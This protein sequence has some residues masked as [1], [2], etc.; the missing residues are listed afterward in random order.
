MNFGT[1]ESSVGNREVDA[2]SFEMDHALPE[3]ALC[4]CTRNRAAS[5]TRCLEH[6]ASLETDRPWELVVVDN[7]S[8][9]DTPAVLEAFGARLPQLRV[10]HEPT[11]GLGRARNS[12]WRASSAPIVAFTDDD[13]YV[14]PD[15]LDRTL[16]VF[17]EDSGLG[18]V[19]G[20]IELW[21][22]SDAKV[23]IAPW[24]SP[25]AF[26]ARSFIA[27]GSFHGANMA[28]RRTAL[29]ATG[30]FDPRFG[31]GTPFAC[32]DIDAAAGVLWAD[33]RG[34]YDP[35]PVVHHH[36]GRKHDEVR[37]LGADYDRG[38]GAYYMKQLLSRGR[39]WAY[40]KAWARSVAGS[41]IRRRPGKSIREFS[42]GMRFLVDHLRR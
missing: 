22:P 20:R 17:S 15:Y 7:G 14:E 34:A 38:R 6:V 18:F 33:Y 11:P 37:K 9:D 35:R 36:H 31:S 26:P 42:S 39:R 19:G 29:E 3:I 12:G 16:A 5:L 24:T 4:I 23:T 8:T 28:F 41:V 10:V 21:D 30:G 40:G 2:P 27:A 25:K 32:E 1:H 13:C